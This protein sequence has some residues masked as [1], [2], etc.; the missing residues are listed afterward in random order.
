MSFSI[1]VHYDNSPRFAQPHLWVW[2]AGSH[3]PQDFA[4]TD[5]DAFGAVFAVQ[6]KRSSFSFKFKEGPGTAGPWE[7]DALNRS[8]RPQKAPGGAPIVNE[9]WC[10]G[11]MAF[12]YPVLPRPP[13][14]QSAASFVAALE[15]PAGLFLPDTGGLTGL[16]GANPLWGVG[17]LFGLY[18]P[19][20][21]RVY[22]LATFNDWQRPGHDNPD[23]ARFHELRLY[24]G[25]FDL[26]NAWLGI[27][28]QAKPG[29]EYKFCVLGGVPRDA[30]GRVQQYFTDPYARRLGPDFGFNNSVVVDPT[31]F[32]WT[33]RD[34]R[35]LDRA[36]LILYE[37]SV[38]GFTE[39]DAASTGLGL[40]PGSPNGFAR[41]TST[42]SAS[43][44]SL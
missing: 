3:Q 19:N 1:V 37:L 34:W 22:V 7:S 36:Q 31:A 17:V 35:T 25:Y 21:A 13:E 40:S 2:F 43:P 10:R 27:V 26:P 9:I 18:H 14:S 6:V 44:P 42:I 39:G 20:A 38:Y 12:V 24:R 8:L 4:P 28:P 11:G 29:D 16:E 41:A 32:P 30:K 15:R 33:D 23:P 5:T